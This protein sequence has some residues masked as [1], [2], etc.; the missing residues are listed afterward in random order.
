MTQPSEREAKIN[1]L[2]ASLA[3]NEAGRDLLARA[4]NGAGLAMLRTVESYRF[5]E[6]DAGRLANARQGVILDTETT[7]FVVG[8]DSV[9]QLAML[10]FSYDD[11]GLIAIGEVFDR[12]RNP[13]K[14]I[15]P[16]VVELTGITDEMVKGKTIACAEVAEFMADCDIVVAHNAAFDRPMCE[17]SFPEA[18]FQTMRWDCSFKQIDWKGRAMPGASLEMLALRSGMVY[19]SH[20]ALNDIRCLAMMLNHQTGDGPTAFAEM[21]A[22]GNIPKIHIV[23]QGSIF[24]KKDDLKE[25]KYRWS[26]DGSEA[27]GLRKNWHITIEGTPEAMEAEAAFLRAHYGSDRALPAAD[28]P[29]VDRYSDRLPAKQTTLFRTGEPSSILDALKQVSATQEAAMDMEP[30][31]RF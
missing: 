11:E 24:D 4:L 27:L 19:G 10:K 13:G 17:A 14:P 25:R 12:L 8:D 23:A 31:F 3:A 29:I 18:G 9:T 30:A 2:I 16:E 5:P 6:V 15:P 20:N 28:I 1:A 22:N 7:G 26:D 21:L